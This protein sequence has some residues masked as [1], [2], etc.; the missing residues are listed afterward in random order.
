MF[1][2]ILVCASVTLLIVGPA[3]ETAYYPVVSVLSIDKIEPINSVSTKVWA[4]YRKLRPCEYVG[5]AWYSFDEKTETIRQ[6]GM[7]LA[8]KAIGDTSSPTRP[9]GHIV[10]GPWTISMPAS[11]I[12]GKSLVEVF[13]RCSVLWISRSHYYP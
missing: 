3:L 13:H 7:T 5:I 4:S 2:V 8:P 10:A 6:V 11:D 9:V 12:K 1:S